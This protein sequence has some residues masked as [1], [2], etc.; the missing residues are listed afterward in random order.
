MI[1]CDAKATVGY[2]RN[3]IVLKKWE[4]DPSDSTLFDLAPLLLG[5][6]HHFL[7]VV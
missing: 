3:T 5:K 7:M 1:D 6:Y 4:G 2:E